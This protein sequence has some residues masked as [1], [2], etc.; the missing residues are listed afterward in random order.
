MNFKETPIPFMNPGPGEDAWMQEKAKEMNESKKGIRLHEDVLLDL[1]YAA[2]GDSALQQCID[3]MFVQCRRYTATV[4]EFEAMIVHGYSDER[5]AEVSATRGRTHDVT[6]SAIDL[7][8]REMK[9]KYFD[10]EEWA[11]ASG[12]GN[13][14]HRQAYG[15]FAISLTFKRIIVQLEA[16]RAEAEDSSEAENEA[17][18]A[19][20]VVMFNSSM[21]LLGDT[22]SRPR[23]SSASLLRK[24]LMEDDVFAI[25]AKRKSVGSISGFTNLISSS[26]SRTEVFLQA[27]Q[28]ITMSIICL[29]FYCN[30]R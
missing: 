27:S 29:F 24:T 19:V 14:E 7:V 17:E 10:T 13:P 15:V 6:I 9:K 11:T 8:L 23:S 16:L 3:D 5:F 4:A 18:A 2:E 20:V 22:P 12:L 1:E 21:N 30:V 28:K 26:L 25:P